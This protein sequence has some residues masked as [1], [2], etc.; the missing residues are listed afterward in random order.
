MKNLILLHIVATLTSIFV[1]TIET[2]IRL[3]RTN[4]FWTTVFEK[5]SF[6]YKKNYG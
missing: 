4:M 6:C 3:A 1:F 2:I 5:K